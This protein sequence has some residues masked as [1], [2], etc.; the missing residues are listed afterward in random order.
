MRILLVEDDDNKRNRIV[1]AIANGVPGIEITEVRSILAAEDALDHY[2]FDLVVLD[3][4]IPTFEISPEEDGG[5]FEALGGQ[6]LLRYMKRYKISAPV[7]VVTQF[8]TFGAGKD[9]RTLAQL[10]IQLR[11]E[12][13]AGYRGAIYY[14][15]ASDEWKMQLVGVAMAV[16]VA[17]ERE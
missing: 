3:M 16:A 2:G 7:V 5:S 8:S 15:T 17:E 9:A 4:S 13:G 10:N 6:E 11:K 14:D 1:S 12:H